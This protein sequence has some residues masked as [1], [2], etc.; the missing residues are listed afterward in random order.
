[1]FRISGIK[2]DGNTKVL[3]F[4]SRTKAGEVYEDLADSEGYLFLVLLEQE[5]DRMEV[6]QS[7]R[8][9][10]LLERPARE[11]MAA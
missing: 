11:P 4:T 1:M 10:P 3:D 8:F 9:P 5:G 7:S 2:N 6:I